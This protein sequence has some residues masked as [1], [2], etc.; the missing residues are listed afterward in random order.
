MISRDENNLLTQTSRGTPAGDLL[1]RYW[2]PVAL[3]EEL[4]SG[5]SPLSVKVLGEDLVLFRDDQGSVGLLGIHCSHRGTDLSFGRVED[6]GLRCL[7]HG[8]LYDVHGR[9]LEQPGEPGGG[10][11]RGAIRHCA[12]PCKEAAGAIFTYMGPGAPPLLPNYDFLNAS[13]DHLYISKIFHECNYQQA[14]EGNI[15]PVHLSYLHRFLEN[16]E[17]NYRG[18]RGANESHYNLVGRNSAPVIDVELVD[19]G[20]RIYTVRKLENDK[21]YLRVSYF[22]LPNLSA[23]PGQTGGEGYSVN[24]HVP[25]DDTH[26]WKY[27]FVYSAG[28]PLKKELV[29]RERS[30]LGPDYRLARNAANRFLQDREA[31]KTKTYAG[32]GSGFQ[33]HDAF[34]TASQGAIQDRTDEHLVTSDKAIVAARKLMEKAISDIQQGREPP[35]VIRAPSENRF[36]HLLVVSDMISTSGDWKEYTKN[37]E[38]EARAKI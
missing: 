1:R 17:E 24:W 8:W 22:I 34:A 5:G 25:I 4:P 6:G 32:M 20:A 18:V 14:N 36:A 13:P 2:Q 27:T 7:Y 10:E 12:Y 26:H 37:L 3:S 29:N 11:H 16:R 23:F 21:M 33:A 9:C 30:E 35:H 28:T 15:D 31:M 38:A 19:F